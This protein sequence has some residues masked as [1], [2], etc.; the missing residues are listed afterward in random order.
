MDAH[1]NNILTDGNQLFLADYGLAMS[2]QFQLN[3]DERQFFD[4]HQNFD[5]CTVINSLV[6]AIVSHYDSREN[7][8]Q[9]LQQLADE[10]HDSN[11][12]VSVDLRAYLNKRMAL[13]MKIGTFYRQL[14]VD[15]TTPYPA[16]D[17]QAIL[18]NLQTLKQS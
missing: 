11:T 9:A 3:A 2:N 18:N 4:Q 8:R 17:L 12:A 1:F 5:I 16:A 13:V 14:L 6:H 10:H 7:W 15:L